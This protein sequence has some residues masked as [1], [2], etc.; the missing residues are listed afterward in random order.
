MIPCP[1][2]PFLLSCRLII[3]LP[4]F[5][6]VVLQAGKRWFY[7][8]NLTSRRGFGGGVREKLQRAILGRGGGWGNLYTARNRRAI[9]YHTKDKRWEGQNTD[10]GSRVFLS[11]RGKGEG[12]GWRKNFETIE[13][14]SFKGKSGVLEEG[15]VLKDGVS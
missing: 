11:F 4:P 2:T 13:G 9:G 6:V 3:V 12:R 7:G 14:G 8:I 15:K 5:L 10:A 1:P